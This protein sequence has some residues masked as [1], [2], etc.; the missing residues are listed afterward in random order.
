MKSKRKI[1][2]LGRILLFFNSL[3]VLALLFIYLGSHINPEFFWPVALP[4]LVFPIVL[5]INLGFVLLWMIRGRL[6]F[7]LS[8]IAII[9]GYG[10]VQSFISL[11]NT[12]RPL[13]DTG[14]NL[15]V[16]SYNVRVF[17][18]YNYGPQW[19]LNFTDRDNIYRFIGEDDFDIICFQEF[20]H[21]KTG[22]FKTLDTIPRIAGTAY[23]HAE[24]TRSSRDINFFGLATFSRYPIINKGLIK[25]PTRAGNLCIYTD[26]KVHED[27]IRVYNV[28]FESIGLSG[29]DYL[30]VEN[31]TN[32][33][34]LP[35]RKYFL[36]GSLRILGYLHS[37]FAQRAV[38]VKLVASHIDESPYPVI[39]AGDFNDTP[40]SY[41]YRVLTRRL[42]D[43]FSS[44]KGTGVTYEWNLPGF[45]IDYIMHTPEFKP[46]NFL[47]GKQDY[48][49]HYP[50]SV[51]LNLENKNAVNTQ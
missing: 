15:H 6:Y 33:E 21:D 26:I 14:T 5:L 34:Q 16:L 40:V 50:V 38:Q 12:S 48:S 46:Y 11:S 10:H 9:I 29:E 17:G 8:L 39:L 42:N 51:W 4:G 41:A 3:A 18:L 24:F 47:T 31:M 1:S 23:A 43:A 22:A 19:E 7:L 44:A 2:F 45:R 27:T 30:F 25:F 35:D 32:V 28:H 36:E 49:D 13:P 20:V 37:A